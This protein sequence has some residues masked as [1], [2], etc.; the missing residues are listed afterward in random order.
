VYPS[1]VNLNALLN[2]GFSEVWNQIMDRTV[3]P[4]CRADYGEPCRTASGKVRRYEPHLDRF[5]APWA[6]P[7][8]YKAILVERCL[9]K[10]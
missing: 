1:G 6:E 9:R 7:E 2:Q 8:Q 3:C 10:G 4:Y 5:N